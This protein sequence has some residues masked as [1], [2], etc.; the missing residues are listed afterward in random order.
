MLSLLRSSPLPPA[1]FPVHSVPVPVLRSAVCFLSPYPDS[2]PQPLLRCSLPAFAFHVFRFRSRFLSSAD[3]PPPAT[4]PL[5]LPFCPP[6]LRLTAGFLSRSRL[7]SSP[8]LF[9]I[10]HGW[11]PVRFTRFRILG[12]LFVSFRPSLLRSH[13]RS[14]GASLLDHS[15]GINA[16]LP[17]PFVPFRFSI[18]LLSL[19]VFLFHFLPGFASQ[20]AAPVL[21][22]RLRFPDPSP[23]PRP[24]FPCHPSGSVYSA[25]CLFPFVLPC[26]APTAVPQVLPFWIAPRGSTH[27]FR[28]LPVP[29]ALASHYSASASSFPCFPLPPRSGFRGALRS[30]SVPSLSPFSPAWFPMHSV[31]VPVLRSPAVP[32]TAPPLRVT[33]AIHGCRPPVSS[34]ATSLC[35][36]FRFR[37][38]SFRLYLF[39]Y[40]PVRLFRVSTRI[41]LAYITTGSSKC[42]HLF[43]TF[44]N[45]FL[46]FSNQFRHLLCMVRKSP[47]RRSSEGG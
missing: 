38:L 20:L 26:F 32:F 47:L 16:W 3:L 42:Q 41:G 28:F 30:L 15:S 37:L 46:A 2:L 13:S 43:C 44:S 7:L 17:V 24:G 29:S 25:S 8:V 27:G 21:L 18:S 34:S 12:F 19:S 22:F 45:C 6:D 4:Q 39:Q 35:F 10:V 9:P 36:R 40:I 1:W 14:T 33:G 11:F 5:L 31:P 23:Y